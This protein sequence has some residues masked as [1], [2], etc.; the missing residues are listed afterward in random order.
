[1]KEKRE[2]EKESAKG[3]GE[4]RGSSRYTG[5]FFMREARMRGGT[6]LRGA[7]CILFG[8]LARY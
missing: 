8:W 7:R 6:G 2:D 5:L 4:K 3:K 1:M